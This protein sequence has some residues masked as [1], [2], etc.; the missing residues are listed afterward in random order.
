MKRVFVFIIMVMVVIGSVYAQ[1]AAAE[2]LIVG[3]W[4]DNNSNRWVF[5]SNGTVTYESLNGRFTGSQVAIIL[6]NG[7]VCIMDV[8]IS[9][10]GRTMILSG[11]WDL[12]LTKN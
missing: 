6:R 2:R 9:S 10:D 1:N 3:T 8:S 4:T 11:Y 7:A 12:L 5:N